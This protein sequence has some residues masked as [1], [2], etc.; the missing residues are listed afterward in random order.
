MAAKRRKTPKPLFILAGI[1]AWLVPGTGH[2]Y[3]GRPVRGVI[4][5]L[6]VGLTFWAGMAMGG[7]M[8]VD[9]QYQPWWFTAQMLTGVHGLGGWY[10]QDQQYQQLREDIP[11]LREPKPAI[12]GRPDDTQMQVDHWL[13]NK[14]IVVSYP[15]ADVARAYTGVAGM[16]NLMCIFDA[17][18]LALMGRGQEPAQPDVRQEGG[19]EA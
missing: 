3:I 18:M 17:I 12:G 4:L 1:L 5:F 2:V 8:T 7:V 9:R 11:D 14:G 19:A 13:R 10:M 16:M 6:A 15:V